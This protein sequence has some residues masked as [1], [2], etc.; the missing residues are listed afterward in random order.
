MKKL[1]SGKGKIQEICDLIRQETLEPADRE[2][3]RLIDEGEHAKAALINEG[4]RQKEE[5]LRNACSQ[6]AQE[7]AIYE[8]SL[9]Q[10][11]RQA[12]ESF[13]QQIEG[14]CREDLEKLVDATM[15]DPQIIAHLIEALITAIDR[16]GLA[17]DLS[18]EVSRHVDVQQ[19]SKLLASKLLSRLRDGS[20]T[21]GNFEDSGAQLVLHDR[22]MRVS[23]TSEDAKNMLAEHIR[24]D[25]RALI[26]SC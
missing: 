11:M 20:V 9:E 23:L 26:F 6:I 25:F 3:K 12:L 19:V 18:A 22:K 16:D 5:L 14:V 10:A 15:V 1:D 7:R 13:K 8:S 4:Q 17:T 2:K 24:K 21:I